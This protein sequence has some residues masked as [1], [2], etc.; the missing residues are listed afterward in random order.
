M[1]RIISLIPILYLSKT[2]NLYPDMQSIS[3]DM[4]NVVI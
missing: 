3:Q 2:G 4:E 1:D